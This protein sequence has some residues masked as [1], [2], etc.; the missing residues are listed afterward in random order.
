MVGNGAGGDGLPGG[1]SVGI[2]ADNGPV[3]LPADR[4]EVNDAAVRA[5]GLEVNEPAF[6]IGGFDITAL[7]R[8]VDAGGALREDHAV[9]V[10]A[11]DLAR[12]QDGLRSMPTPPK[13][14]K[15]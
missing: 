14:A 4:L 12:A 1:C 9:V 7:M 2:V 10:G 15:M 8:A 5:I 3:V 13:G 11:V 6:A